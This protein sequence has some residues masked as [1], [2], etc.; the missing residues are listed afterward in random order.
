MWRSI[1]SWF[2][3]VFLWWLMI[4]SI[5]SRAYWPSIY[6]CAQMFLQIL[7]PFLSYL[8]GGRGNP[9][10][11]SCLENPFDRGACQATVHGVTKTWTWLKQLSMHT[12]HFIIEWEEFLM[13]SLYVQVPYQIWFANILFYSVQCHFT[14]LV[15][16]FETHKFFILMKSNLSKISLP[17]P[18]VMK[19]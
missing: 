6:V 5:F 10:Q 12:C 17:N 14:F 4:L 13:C 3:C 18:K 8:W 11:Y 19:I 16:L 15:V 9:L 7:C 2:S 1:S